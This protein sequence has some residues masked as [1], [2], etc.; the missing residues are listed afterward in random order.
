MKRAGEMQIQA[1]IEWA[2]APRQSLQLCRTFYSLSLHLDRC[3]NSYPNNF[4]SQQRFLAQTNALYC[5]HLPLMPSPQK[6]LKW[7]QNYLS[8]EDPC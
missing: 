8:R 3:L 2:S 4:D 5:D 7:Q 6:S 1:P